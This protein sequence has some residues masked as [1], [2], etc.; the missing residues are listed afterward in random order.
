[1]RDD[2]R[3]GSPLVPG[4]RFAYRVEVPCDGAC[5]H[6]A[7]RSTPAQ[8]RQNSRFG[9]RRRRT[10][11]T[12]VTLIQCK[13]TP[14]HVWFACVERRAQAM[15]SGWAEEGEHCLGAKSCVTLFSARKP[16]SSWA[17]ADPDRL[18][19]MT[20]AGQWQFRTPRVEM[21]EMQQ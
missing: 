8:R 12:D 1:M 11:R 13:E 21:A 4:R 16:E 18:R 14:A 5:R 15:C 17:H 10:H 20:A 19:Q 6:E 3:V 7:Q 2:T 9:I